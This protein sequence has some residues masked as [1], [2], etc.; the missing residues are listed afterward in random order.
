MKEFT[1]TIARNFIYILGGLTLGSI[2]ITPLGILY[3]ALACKNFDRFDFLIGFVVPGYGTI[4][5][6]S[7]AI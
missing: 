4:S 1:E 5:A 2:F 6:I 3:T 7:C